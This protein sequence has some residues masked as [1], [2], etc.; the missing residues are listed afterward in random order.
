MGSVQAKGHAR[1]VTLVY[2]GAD[3]V[4]GVEADEEGHKGDSEENEEERPPRVHPVARVV[5]SA[6][7]GADSF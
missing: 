3:L 6:H 2:F 7:A 5:R 4:E 1:G